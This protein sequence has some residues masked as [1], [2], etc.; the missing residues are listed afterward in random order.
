VGEIKMTE[1]NDTKQWRAW[2]IKRNTLDNVVSYI[3]ANCPEIDKFF[4]PLIKKEY[5]T[6]S[7]TK[8]V[9]DMPLYEGYLFLRYNNHAE[10]FHKLSRYPQVTTYCGAVKD[11]EIEVMRKAQG[12]LLSELKASKFA[13]G[14][15]VLLKDGPFKGYE[16]KVTSVAGSTIKVR[17][18]AVLLGVSGHEVIYLEEHLEHKTELQNIEVQE[19]LR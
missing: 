19:I 10:V 9:R 17:V 18:D 8:K 7:G 13:K 6:K 16:A 14:D 12:K 4:Y 11:E 3:Q 1:Q 15:T 2:V 5:Q